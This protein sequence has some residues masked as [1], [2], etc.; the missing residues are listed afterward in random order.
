MDILRTRLG[1]S[2]VYE[3]AALPDHR[4]EYAWCRNRLGTQNVAPP[5]AGRHYIG[6]PCW[7]LSS[8]KKLSPGIEPEHLYA[9][10]WIQGGWWEERD[11]DR[12]YFCKL[13][14]RGSRG[15]LYRDISGA[16]DMPGV[17]LHGLF[18]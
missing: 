3:I 8:P 12:Q 18:G 10:E 13:T 6:R 11:I 9:Q 1:D 2:Q 15:W 4:P 17:Y 14:A 16:E 7:L 5:S